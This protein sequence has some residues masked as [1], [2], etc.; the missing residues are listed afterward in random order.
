MAAFVLRRLGFL[1]VVV[2]AVTVIT[3]LIAQAIPGDPARVVAGPRAD[4]QQLAKA[5]HQLGLDR[6]LPVRYA[7]YLGRVLHGDLGASI[8]TGRPVL[9]ELAAR[10]PATL[11]LMISALIVG[12]AGGVPLGVA[13]ALTR[14][15]WPDRLIRA[16]SALTISVPAFW[17]G[18][19]LIL[20][21]YGALQVL[22]GSGRL[23]LDPPPP[24]TGF[25]LIDTLLA[26]DVAAFGDALAH[27]AIPVLT[28]ALLDVGAIARLVR[29]QMIEVLGEDYI[30][31]ARATGLSEATVILRYAL[32]N[33]LTPLVTVLGLSIAQMLYGSVVIESIFAWPGDG[34]YVVGAIFNLDFP[35]VLGFALVTSVAYVVVNLGVDL[36]YL[37]LDPRIREAG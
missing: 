33:G 15:R 19:L 3:F 10:A 26:G 13:A 27:L 30:R 34:S 28:L 32:R 4:A 35:V 12:V 8:V 21:F 20:V 29:G 25:L 9:S 16:G 24:V 7:D 23:D 18:P 36:T 11:E 17:L 1:V 31:T 22:P 14:G 6:P 37:L 2:L 5:R